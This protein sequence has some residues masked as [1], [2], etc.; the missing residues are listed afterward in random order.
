LLGIGLLLNIPLLLILVLVFWIVVP[1]DRAVS[2]VVDFLF[3]IH[4]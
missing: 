3:R 1:L 4:S 2:P